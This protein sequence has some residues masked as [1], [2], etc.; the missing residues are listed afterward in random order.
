MVFTIASIETIGGNKIDIRIW[1][2]TFYWS[3]LLS[4]LCGI[5]HTIMCFIPHK[6]EN[7]CLETLQVSLQNLFHCH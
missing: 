2:T 1:S 6:T 4:V 7:Y 5:K 3:L